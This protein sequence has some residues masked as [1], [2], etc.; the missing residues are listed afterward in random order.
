MFP[1][2]RQ[3]VRMRGYLADLRSRRV[4]ADLV[5]PGRPPAVEIVEAAGCFL[6]G[7]FARRPHLSPADFPD[8]TGL[9]C[10]ANKLAMSGLVEPRLAAS[11][12]LLLLVAGLMTAQAVALELAQFDARFNIILSYDGESCVVRFHKI[13]AGERWLAADLEAYAADEGLLVIEAGQGVPGEAVARL[14]S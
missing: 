12:P 3:N 11:C 1:A 9:E 13:R 4:A 6:L 7:R 10:I 8:A 5:V 14:A 2:M